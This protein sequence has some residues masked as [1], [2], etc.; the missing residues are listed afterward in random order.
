LSVFPPHCNYSIY[1][2]DDGILLRICGDVFVFLAISLAILFSTFLGFA[3]AMVGLCIS[4]FNLIALPFVLILWL[5][6]LIPLISL[7]TD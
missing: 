5:F 6:I 2:N 3:F 1:P 7:F 4:P